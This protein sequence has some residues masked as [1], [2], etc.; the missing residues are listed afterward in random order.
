MTNTQPQDYTAWIGRGVVD[1]AGE[2]VGKVNAIFLD[3]Q[4]GEPEWLAVSTGLLA[5]RSSFV[6][7]QGATATGDE[8]VITY[9]KA[10]VK[11]A[12]SVDDDG[13]GHLTPAEEQ[14]L[15]R[16]YG[17]ET[18]PPAPVAQPAPVAEPAQVAQPA[19]VAEPA[20]L[21]GTTGVVATAETA[22]STPPLATA[23]PA[24]VGGD[25]A[26]TLSEEQI[27]VAKQVQESGRARL[28]KFIVTEQVTQTVPVQREEVHIEREPIIDATPGVGELSEDEREVTLHAEVPVVEKTVVP[29]ERVRLA[30]ETVT[31]EETVTAEV[32]KEQ[33][34]Q[35]EIDTTATPPTS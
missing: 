20:P 30:T 25:D 9:D 11:G 12:P 7:L 10:M 1:Q 35:V 31:G 29:V 5:K 17:R 32:R 21:A 4:T 8:L 34:D 19:Q 18:T 13:D 15:Y 33:V 14:E 23:T 24:A 2:K 6:P 28:R 27:S 26:M 3:D 16:Y 22:T